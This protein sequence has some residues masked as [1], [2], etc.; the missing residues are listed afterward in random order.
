MTIFN[1]HPLSLNPTMSKRTT[2][3]P[4]PPSPTSVASFLTEGWLSPNR[5]TKCVVSGCIDDIIG[6]KDYYIED[7]QVLCTRAF[8]I[9]AVA[10]TIDNGAYPPGCTELNDK[11][12]HNCKMSR[13]LY[14][15][16]SLVV[17]G[18]DHDS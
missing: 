1:Q 14:T 8:S 3:V 12:G 7:D 16:F 9:V 15:S 10:T 2:P 6:Y 18:L 11:T 5:T 13:R 4:K 17:L